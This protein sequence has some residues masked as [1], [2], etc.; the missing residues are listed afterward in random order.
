M[1]VHHLDSG[2]VGDDGK[3]VHQARFFVNAATLDQDPQVVMKLPVVGPLRARFGD[4]VDFAACHD[5]FVHESADVFL[6][7]TEFALDP[8]LRL[9]GQ[10][11][12]DVTAHVPVSER[13]LVCRESA[14]VGYR[15]H[16]F[17]RSV[18]ATRVIRFRQSGLSS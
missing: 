8:P 9:C 5:E 12:Q 15:R 11:K 6:F 14:R 17:L 2:V 13:V 1:D 3:L 7:E 18:K 10:I 4:L 16:R